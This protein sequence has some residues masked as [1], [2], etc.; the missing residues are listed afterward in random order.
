MADTTVAVT[1][2]TGTSVHFQPRSVTTDAGAVTAQSQVIVPGGV[3]GTPLA[4]AVT[5]GT[6]AAALPASALTNRKALYVHNAG[7]F[8]IYLGGSGVTSSTGIPL[9][10]GEGRGFDLAA[11]CVLYAISVAAG[12]D[13]RVLE[14]S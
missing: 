12:Q 7:S 11:G 9:E 5:V 10:P 8:A 1:P 3:A 4:S 6:S 13:V 2:G 14:V